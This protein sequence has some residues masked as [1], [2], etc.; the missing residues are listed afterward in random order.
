MVEP[1]KKTKRA[2]GVVMMSFPGPEALKR[3]ITKLARAEG[4]TNSEWMRIK[5]WSVVRR[6]K[7]AKR[8]A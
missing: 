2:D 4:H 7:A 5:L 3:E 6:S 8:A 1:T